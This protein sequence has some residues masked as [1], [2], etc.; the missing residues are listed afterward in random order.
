MSSSVRRLFVLFAAA[1]SFFSLCAA[2]AL[3]TAV[4]T[5]Y[6]PKLHHFEVGHLPAILAAVF[7]A[8]GVLTSLA[9]ALTV[10]IRMISAAPAVTVPVLFTSAL[11]GFL[12]LFIFVLTI[13]SAETWMQRIRLAIMALSA[14][15]FLISTQRGTA[16]TP[17][18][19]L[20]SLAP[21]VYAFLSVMEVYFDTSMGMN[22]PLKSYY[23]MMY[24]AMALFFTAEARVVLDRLQT[25]AYCLFAGLC[26]VL[27]GAVGLSHILFT[28]RGYALPLTLPQSIAAGA[29]AVYAALRLFSLQKPSRQAAGSTGETEA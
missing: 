27:T 21:I 2:A 14:F 11:V 3:T 23:L 8:L 15:S 5:G 26:T 9:F 13:P 28:L 16:V 25:P 1:L 24:L 22:A 10:R 20:L 29:I 18:R 12:F 6:D 7:C 19:A 17:I 4:L